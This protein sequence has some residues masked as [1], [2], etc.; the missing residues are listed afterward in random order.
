MG[1][2]LFCNDD[3]GVRDRDGKCMQV[4]AVVLVPAVAEVLVLS[5]AQRD[6]GVEARHAVDQGLHRLGRNETQ[7]DSRVTGGC[8]A[9]ADQM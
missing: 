1:P 4:R 3:L 9:S 2:T 8:R 7:G 5:F 6:E